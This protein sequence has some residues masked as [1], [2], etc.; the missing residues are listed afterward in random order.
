MVE[1]RLPVLT[2]TPFR[3]SLGGGST[4][5]PSYYQKYGG[6]IFG[7]TINMYVDIFMKRL[8]MDRRIELNYRD[9]EI[10]DEVS[11][12]KNEICREALRMTGIGDS[13][14]IT[15]NADSPY[16]TGLGSSGSYAIG[17]LNGLYHLQGERKSPAELAEKAFE[18]TQ[19]LK[20][21]DGKQDPYLAAFGGFTVFEVD[22]E[23]RVTVIRPRIGEKTREKFLQRCLLFYTDIKRNSNDILKEQNG[24]KV[25]ELKHRTK[26]I[27]RQ[28]L[29]AFE[30]GRLDD[31]GYLMHEHWEVKRQM[32]SIMTSERIDYWYDLAR[33]HGVLGGKIV[34]AG[35]GGYFLFYCPEDKRERLISVL[36]RE[37]LKEID[38]A[39][40]ERG[41]QAVMPSV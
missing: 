7:V 31:F 15:F 30:S 34:G 32:I 5:L 36:T 6:F 10:V 11:Q 28:V 33:K 41:T 14:T 4:D 29:E 2:R 25:L 27:G 23:G 20:L 26:A 8:L 3:L 18:L 40:E 16:G 9:R 12:L 1:M 19:R 35:G 21:S 39:I 13:V 22:H 17:L 24:E 38:F 37:G